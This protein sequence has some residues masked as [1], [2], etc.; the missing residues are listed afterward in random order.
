MNREQELQLIRTCLDRYREGSTTLFAAE[1]MSPVERYTCAERFG[2]EME[3]IHRQMPTPWVHA[4][5][6]AEP[7]AFRRLQTSI[8]DVLFTRDC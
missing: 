3:V 8:G 1:V 7:N 4:G 5:E 2:R 6:L